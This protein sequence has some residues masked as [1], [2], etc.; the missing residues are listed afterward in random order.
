[1]NVLFEDGG[2]LRAGAILSEQPGAVLVELPGGKR[3]KVRA[4]RVL[5]HF[6]RPQPSELLTEAQKL[7]TE[8]DIDRDER[9]QWAIRCHPMTG[10][11]E[12]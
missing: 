10:R 4:D 3:E 2:A 7:A 6:P 12:P 1:M 11:L 8:V 5:L 9:R